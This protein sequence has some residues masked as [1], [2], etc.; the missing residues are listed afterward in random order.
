VDNGE[1]EDVDVGIAEFPVCSVNGQPVFLLLRKHLEN[2]SGDKV[3][4]DG[5]FRKKPLYS[6]QTRLRFGGR[7]ETGR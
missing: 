2:E 1:H 3:L 6:P 7:V 5:M 4:A